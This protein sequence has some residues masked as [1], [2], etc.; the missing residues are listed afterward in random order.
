MNI[1]NI[2]AALEEE[3]EEIRKDANER[4]NSID[5][6]IYSLRQRHSLPNS[7]DFKLNGNGN[8][9]TSGFNQKYKGYE[10]LNTRQKALSIF[11]TEGRFL[12]MREITKIAQSLE[13]N[14]DQKEI[15]RKISTAIYTMKN[16]PSSSVTNVSIENSNQNTFWGSKNWLD[17][18]GNVKKEHMYNEKEIATKQNSLLEI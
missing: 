7:K 17:E 11:R 10:K 1:D 18:N 4:I 2:I 6:A 12:H 16:I 15:A 3:K 5:V 14:E 9:R 8:E 13:P